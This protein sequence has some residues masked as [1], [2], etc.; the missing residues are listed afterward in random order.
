MT[1]LSYGEDSNIKLYTDESVDNP[2]YMYGTFD[3]DNIK[4]KLSGT[5]NKEHIWPCSQM[6]LD[7]NDP[8]PDSDTKNHATDLHNLRASCQDANGAY[9]NKFYDNE[10]TNITLFINIE[11]T[12]NSLH[13]YEGDLR[14]VVARI[15]FYMATR[16]DFLGLNDDWNVENDTFM[17]KLS[18]L[19]EWNELDPVD[20]FEIERNNRIYEYQGNITLY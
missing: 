11:G 9:G 3:G 8:R 5:L 10:N 15:S 12:P 19:L 16:Y 13:L 4:A 18:T 2:G 6:K 17:S 7:G 20:D 14:G 1:K